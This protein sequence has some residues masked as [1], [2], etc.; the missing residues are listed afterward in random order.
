VLVLLRN[1]RTLAPRATLPGDTPRPPA[2]VACF[3]W[4]LCA[5]PCLVPATARSGSAAPDDAAARELRI[6]QVVES[7]T[8]DVRKL[9]E[10]T[11][12]TTIGRDVLEQLPSRRIGDL[13]RGVPNLQVHAAL[14]PG[15]PARL[16]LRGLGAPQDAAGNGAVGVDLDGVPLTHVPLSLLV[17]GDLECVEVQR[18][19]QS[20]IGPGSALAGV[21]RV[22]TRRPTQAFEAEARLRIADQIESGLRLNVPLLPEQ[23]ALRLNLVAATRG[24]LASP[25]LDSAERPL[26]AGRLQLLAYPSEHL[27]V[28]LDADFALRGDAADDVGGRAQLSL[29]LGPDRTLVATSAWREGRADGLGAPGGLLAATSRRGISQEIRLE[30]RSASGVRYVVGAFGARERAR[31]GALTF[32]SLDRPGEDPVEGLPSFRVTRRSHALHAR[33]TVPLT[34]SLELTLGARAGQRRERVEEGD[35]ACAATQAGDPGGC[36]ERTVRDRSARRSDLSSMIALGW[37]PRSGLRLYASAARGPLGGGFEAGARDGPPAEL[38][39]EPLRVY[40]LGLKSSW[41]EERLLVNAALFEQQL[42]RL[43]IPIGEPDIGALPADAGI[44]SR[45]W[46]RDARIRGAELEVQALP[47]EG[48]RIQASLGWLRARYRG[49]DGSLGAGVLPGVAER[50][51][52]LGLDYESSVGAL[53]T[54]AL[55]ASWSH[56]SALLPAAG[57]ARS[58]GVSLLDARLSLLRP[59]AR[60]ELAVF[61]TNLLDDA[62]PEYGGIFAGSIGYTAR[63]AGP[64]RRFGVELRRVF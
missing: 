16:Q 28:A 29:E 55:S 62:D 2:W 12:V 4:S 6:D 25:I 9:E 14:G 53:G 17:L 33:A 34:S 24:G 50:T 20:A 7:L 44:V 47:W 31:T 42:D 27:E 51:V 49:M 15:Q 45:Q 56:R 32:A 54:L 30:G 10:P 60:T 21:L 18:G 11:A 52:G 57:T 35:P 59:D 41:L 13:A 40:E 23:A 19:P 26:G 61:G 43:L 48:L 3:F 58:G 46:A 64:S 63:A 38:S 5:L 1:L 22:R 39:A 8:T 36:V 37:E